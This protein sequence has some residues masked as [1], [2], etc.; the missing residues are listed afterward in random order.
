MVRRKRSVTQCWQVRGNANWN[1]CTVK[2]VSQV[3][4]VTVASASLPV[5][6]KIKSLGMITDSSLTF[7]AHVTAV[8]K[9]CD[10]TWSSPHTPSTTISVAQTLACSLVG[11]RLDY[12][13]SILYDAPK[14]TTHK[15]QRTQKLLVTMTVE[16]RST[17]VPAYLHIMLTSQV[18]KGQFY[19][20]A[21]RQLS[22]R[23]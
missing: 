17:A 2:E 20:P 11:A 15:L 4:K 13:K 6:S 22:L 5:S 1:I 14:S 19:R 16:V 21:W 23:R 9:S 3:D 12:C 7:D 8:C 10:Y 18:N